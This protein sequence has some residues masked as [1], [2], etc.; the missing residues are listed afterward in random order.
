M[1]QRLGEAGVSIF[2]FSSNEFLLRP[3]LYQAITYADAAGILCTLTSN[4]ALLTKPVVQQLKAAGFRR[5]EVGLVGCT[6]GTH[7]FLRNILGV[8]DATLQNFKLALPLAS[9]KSVPL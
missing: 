1:I 2:N 3:D 7:D 8:F 4:G 9:M 5:I 6:A